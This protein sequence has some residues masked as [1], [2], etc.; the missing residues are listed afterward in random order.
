MTAPKCV[1]A[2]R[3]VSPLQGIIARAVFMAALLAILLYFDIH[4]TLIDLLHWVDAQ[5]IWGPVLLVLLMALVVALVLPRG[6]A[7]PA[8]PVFSWQAQC[9]AHRFRVEPL[10][11]RFCN[12]RDHR[13]L[14]E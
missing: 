8:I 14:S 2:K 6:I 9:G 3:A 10:R 5:A 7:D 13:V 12:D 4:H 1:P 11:W